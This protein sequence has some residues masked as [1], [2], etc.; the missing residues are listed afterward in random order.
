MRLAMESG[1]KTI[2]SFVLVAVAAVCTACA[3][4]PGSSP[5]YPGY[6]RVMLDGQERYCYA[7]GSGTERKAVCFTRVQ[8]QQAQLRQAQLLQNGTSP[9]TPNLDAQQAGLQLQQSVGNIP[10]RTP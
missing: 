1:M 6:K 2:A 3:A 4:H 5:D 10:M 7:T 8:V 9:P